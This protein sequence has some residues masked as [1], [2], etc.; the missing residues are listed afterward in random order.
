MPADCTLEVSHGITALSSGRLLAPAAT[1]PAQDRL[2]EQ[3]LVAVSDD[4]GATWPS[5]AV[6][7]ED[8]GGK[9]GYFEQKLVE[10]APGR[11]LA[12]CWTVTLGDMADREDSF[13]VSNDEGST[14]SQPVSTGIRGQTMSPIPIVNYEG[15]LY[16][17]RATRER[18]EH[19]DAG[20]DELEALEFGFPTAVRLRDGTFLA[21][22][23]SKEG[24]KVGI[25]WTKLR[26]DF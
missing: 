4:G 1:L 2:G 22:H 7:F 16:D 8:P 3:V 24:C 25:R 17:A 18:P 26:V 10:V 14:W 19:A 5:H 20:L 23:W 6:V 12:T 21:T 13:S 11:V 15:V 9:L